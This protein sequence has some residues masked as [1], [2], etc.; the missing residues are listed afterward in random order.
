[1]ILSPVFIILFFSNP[2]RFSA[3]LVPWLICVAVLNVRLNVILGRNRAFGGY[4][5]HFVN[6]YS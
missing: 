4:M 1:M 5:L 2:L 3:S 6:Q